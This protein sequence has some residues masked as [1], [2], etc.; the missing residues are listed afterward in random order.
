MSDKSNKVSQS[1]PNGSR[2][3]PG[4]WLWVLVGA[5][6]LAA[7]AVGYG[8]L[9][10]TS[11]SQPVRAQGTIHEPPLPASGFTWKYQAYGLKTGR[12]AH[13]TRGPKVTV[14]MLMASWCLYCAY[15]D[16]YSWPAVLNTPGLH[17]DVVDVSSYGGI[18][19]PGPKTPA[20]SGHDNVGRRIGI[21][22]M[23]SVMTRYIRAFH[24]ARP[25]V[26]V[27]VEPQSQAY[28]H[29]QYF[30]TILFLNAKG[31]LVDRVNGGIDPA[32]AQK[33]IRTIQKSQ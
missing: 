11:S 13:L 15:V 32:Q 14:V 27:F 24:L 5:M 9:G 1:R 4:W 20:F 25:N 31:Q 8:G 29:V 19:N 16:R 2:R 10:G 18:G 23:R 28:F 22:G 26:S 6:A 21:S 33:I 17:L 30:P 7:L 3:Q 12:P